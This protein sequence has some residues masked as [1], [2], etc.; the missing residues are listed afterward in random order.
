MNTKKNK[1]RKYNKKNKNKLKGSRFTVSKMIKSMRGSDDQLSIPNKE[2]FLFESPNYK[3][4][5]RKTIKQMTIENKIDESNYKKL[6]VLA[7]ES[8]KIAKKLDSNQSNKIK[9]IY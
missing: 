3:Y 4:N 1:T 2:S 9:K 8:R 5:S 6:S 7:E